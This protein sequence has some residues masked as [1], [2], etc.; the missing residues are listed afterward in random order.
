MARACNHDRYAAIC[1]CENRRGSRT[2]NGDQLT[3]SNKN[4]GVAADEAGARN[5]K[6]SPFKWNYCNDN[7]KFG[8]DFAEKFLDA[9]EVGNDA[10]VLM[11]KQNNL[12][13]RTVGVLSLT[14]S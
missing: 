1:T 6:S 14:D 8:M 7:I 12:A 3:T 9:R 4:N 13:G 10:R 2:Y 11:N 5:K